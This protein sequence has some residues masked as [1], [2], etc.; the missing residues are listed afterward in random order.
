[1]SRAPRS[2]PAGP[3]AL[4]GSPEAKRKAAVI[5]EAFAGLRTTQQ[6]SDELGIA[7]A[8]YYVLET[9]MLQA[10]ITALEPI[11]RGRK[12]SDDADRKQLEE[13]NCRLRREVLRLQSLYRTTQR[14]VG[15]QDV[16]KVAKKSKSKT[17]RVR[18]PRTK[19]R[20][21]RV[22]AG[23]AAAASEPQAGSTNIAANAKE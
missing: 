14:A 19:S 18:R 22:L 4:T 15:V 20:G 8:R 16:S 6:A 1:M 13:A 23:L 21:E 5:L 9:R 10:M 3:K 17:T 7:L 11:P 12:R 2:R